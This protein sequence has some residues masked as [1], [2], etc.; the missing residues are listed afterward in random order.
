[1]GWRVRLGGLSRQ[2]EEEYRVEGGRVRR[3]GEGGRIITKDGK[4][5]GGIVY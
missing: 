4:R 5:L 1:M 3:V 2:E